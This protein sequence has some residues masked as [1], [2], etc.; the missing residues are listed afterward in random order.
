MNIFSL[1]ILYL[2]ELINAQIGENSLDIS[3]GVK[4]CYNKKPKNAPKFVFKYSLKD[5]IKDTYFHIKRKFY[6]D[7]LT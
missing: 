3:Q 2:L 5:R 7:R 1:R 4:V 6:E